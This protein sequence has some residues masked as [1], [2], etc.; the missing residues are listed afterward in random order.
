M[1]RCQLCKK[2]VPPRTKAHRITVETRLRRYPF[3]FNVGTFRRN[4]KL[5]FRSDPGGE[6][7]EIVREVIACPD[8]AAQH[9]PPV[10]G[11]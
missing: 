8:C 10:K 11:G 1:Y 9:K 7:R 4:G 3:Q 6:G 2:V 5:Y